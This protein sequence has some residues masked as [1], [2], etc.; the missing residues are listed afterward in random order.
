MIT[1]E[2]LT[3]RLPGFSLRDINLRIEEH[4]FFILMGPTGAGKTVLLEALAG[5][6]PATAGK[7]F[8]GKKDITRLPPE[9]RDVSIVYQDFALFPHLTVRENITYG[10][11]FHKIGTAESKK[12]LSCMLELLNLSHL[13]KR[14]PTN[15]SGGEKQRVSL[16]RA[17]MV[18]PKVLL[19]DEPLSSLDPGFRE[20]V[21]NM[22]K[23]LHKDSRATFL[24]VTHDFAEALSLAGKAA[25]LN[26][27]MVEQIGSIE[28]IFQRPSSAFVA[29]FVGMKNLFS[30]EF[31]GTKTCIDGLEIELEREPANSHGYIA[32]RPEDIVLSREI[33]HSSMRNSF[34]GTVAGVVD[35]GFY[36]EVK[37]RVGKTV[38]NSLITKSS[39]VELAIC[40]GSDIFLSFKATAIHNF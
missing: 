7:I 12:R 38:F 18:N 39:L 34:S 11:H 32:I 37:V 28:E 40:E 20:E 19:L 14:V 35:Q 6:I 30:A 1:I 24:M 5:L 3:V 10:L 13:Q 8:I 25:I 33:L 36:Y 23:K 4:D 26:R 2:D 9:K 27:G 29:D 22:I 31:R 17:L 21:R 16:A 15:L